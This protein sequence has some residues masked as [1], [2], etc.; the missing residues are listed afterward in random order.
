MYLRVFDR[1]EPACETLLIFVNFDINHKVRYLVNRIDEMLESSR[2][3][4]VYHTI[5]TDAREC[6]VT[7][8]CFVNCSAK[9][10]SSLVQNEILLNRKQ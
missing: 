6:L 9:Y 10:S 5:F 8:L 4:Y 7:F 3:N 2:Y 1:H